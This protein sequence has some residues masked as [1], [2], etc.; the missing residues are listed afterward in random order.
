MPDE[1][2]KA[3]YSAQD[4]VDLYIKNG[5]TIFDRNLG[6]KLTNLAGMVHAKYS[7]DPLYHLLT[8]YFGDVTLDKLIKPSLITSYDITERR[9]VFF[10][11]ADARTDS[12]YNFYVKDVAR[13]TSAAP[14]YFAPAHIQSLNGQLFALVD[15]GMFANN[16]ALCA[17]AEARSLEFSKFFNDPGKKDKPSAADMIIVSMGTGSVK[18]R[19]RYDE[20]KNAGELKWLEPVIDILMSGNSETV[21]YQ[22]TQMYLTLDPENQK[23]YHRMEPDLKEACSEMDIATTENVNNLYQAGLSFVHDNK[24]LL[25]QIADS[26]L[27][28]D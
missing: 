16:P 24:S 27:E 14:T 17:Y 23:N 26:L 3:K 2:G 20:F 8:T 6:Q 12:I 9:A 5:H 19:Y 18:K 10:T 28:N 22:L 25:E 11:S 15:G 1:E 4:A 7:D 13:A 21:A